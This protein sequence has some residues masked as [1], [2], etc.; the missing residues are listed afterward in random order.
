MDYTPIG[1]GRV[2]AAFGLTIAVGLMPIIAIVLNHNPFGVGD[3]YGG[4]ALG[5]GSAVV[6]AVLV[7]LIWLAV[8]F[9]RRLVGRPSRA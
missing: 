1:I 7:G 3:G 6:T 9:G 8:T 5:I 2:L 4:L